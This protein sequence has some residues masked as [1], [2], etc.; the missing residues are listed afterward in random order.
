MRASRIKQSEDQG[1]YLGNILSKKAKIIL[2]AIVLGGIIL[3]CFA[4]NVVYYSIFPAK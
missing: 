2:L 3:Y 1:I 4:F